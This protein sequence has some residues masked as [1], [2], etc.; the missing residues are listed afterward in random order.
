MQIM[1]DDLSGA[2]VAALLSEHLAGM[3]EHSPPDSVHALDLD[4]LRAPGIT[5]W[6]ARDGAELMGCGALKELDASH[7]EIKSMRTSGAHLR[8]GVAA[9]LLEHILSEA[10][11]ARLHAPQPRDRFDRAFRP[12][13]N[14]LRPVWI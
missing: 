2:D 14:P 11:A 12:G 13:A 10:H 9:R 6:T 3:A 4:A 7:G 8:K 5:F 1:E